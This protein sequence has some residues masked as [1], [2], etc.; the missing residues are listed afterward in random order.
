MVLLFV[1]LIKSFFHADLFYSLTGRT[2][3]YIYF[4]VFWVLVGV[5]DMLL[6]KGIIFHSYWGENKKLKDVTN[7]YAKKEAAHIKRAPSFETA[8]LA[9]RRR[10]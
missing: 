4:G 3:V 6:L 8:A 1:A 10:Y 9:L 2:S 5:V 7:W